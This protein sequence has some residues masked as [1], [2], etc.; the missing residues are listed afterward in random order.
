MVERA[1]AC[2]GKVG[3]RSGKDAAKA[4]LGLLHRKNASPRC[5][6]SIYRCR[7]CSLWHLG[8][9]PKANLKRKKRDGA[10]FA[11]RHPGIND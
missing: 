9:P 11:A 2:D 8:N 7:F 10:R 6:L 5:S 4:K 3:F 1:S